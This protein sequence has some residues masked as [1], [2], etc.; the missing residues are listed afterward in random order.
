MQRAY[1]LCMLNLFCLENVHIKLLIQDP[2]VSNSDKKCKYSYFV[3]K[4]LCIDSLNSYI[5]MTKK[6]IIIIQVLL[7]VLRRKWK[8][9]NHMYMLHNCTCNVISY[10]YI[11]IILYRIYLRISTTYQMGRSEW[12]F[13][14]LSTHQMGRC[15]W[16]FLFL[17]NLVLCSK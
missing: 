5:M 17:S 2:S 1:I 3:L 10:M 9:V 16:Y 14:F 6:E 13:L 12:Y 11:M 8:W 7:H 4:L 15:E